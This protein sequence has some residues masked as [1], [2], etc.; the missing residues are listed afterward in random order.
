M[1]GFIVE[2][3]IMKLLD[4][5]QM[6]DFYHFNKTNFKVSSSKVDKYLHSND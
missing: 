1:L 6:V 3:D 5:Q 4:E 2:D